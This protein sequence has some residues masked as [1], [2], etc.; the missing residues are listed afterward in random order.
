M[1]PKKAP[2]TKEELEAK[3]LKKNEDARAKYAKKSVEEKED[4]SNQERARREVLKRK[5]TPEQN[6]ADLADQA[7]R[8]KLQR[9][10]TGDIDRSLPEGSRPR[11]ELPMETE[12]DRTTRL[13][14]SKFNHEFDRSEESQQ[15]RET[16]ILS[17]RLRQQARIETATPDAA[18]V[19]RRKNAV[20]TTS[21]RAAEDDIET[22]QRREENRLRQARRR[23]RL[24]LQ[25][26][27]S[28][29]LARAI[30]RNKE[31]HFAIPYF[32]LPI[33]SMWLLCLSLSLILPLNL[34]P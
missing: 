16:R 10:S 21:S 28:D 14:Q 18:E 3:R 27:E 17:D 32:L 1:P 9:Q 25:R 13:N 26:E 7:G 5:K 12:K 6:A 4:K 19:R 24:L 31:L 15:E 2:L 8:R 30:R 20:Q 22:A 33:I 34:D 23:E 11:K 29:N